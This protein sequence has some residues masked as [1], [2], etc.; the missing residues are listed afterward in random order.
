MVASTNTGN[1]NKKIYTVT[2]E[3]G[4]DVKNNGITNTGIDTSKAVT[5][6]L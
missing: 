1:S 5:V 4:E 3:G 2:L 6:A